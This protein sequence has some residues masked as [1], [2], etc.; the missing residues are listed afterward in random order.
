MH[1][2]KLFQRMTELVSEQSSSDFDAR[3]IG[4]I[5]NAYAQLSI[6]D[7]DLIQVC[8]PSRCYPYILSLDTCVPYPS[9]GALSPLAMDPVSRVCPGP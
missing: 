3:I 9:P 4:I 5:L 8:A 6:R 1:D 2:P 7:L